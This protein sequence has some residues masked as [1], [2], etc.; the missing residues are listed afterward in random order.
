MTEALYE[1]GFRRF[2]CGGAVGFDT[3]AASCVL[4]LRESRPDARLIL[5]LPCEDQ[6]FHWTPG[7]RSLYRDIREKADRAIVLSDHYYNG[8][9]MVRNRF[10]AYH[11]SFCVAYWLGTA[12]GGTA[13]TVRLA[14][15]KGM[16]VL[17]IAIPEEVRVFLRDT[18]ERIP[19]PF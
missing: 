15:R 1:R 12:S 2:L 19:L 7:E 17:N 14:L 10:M 8:C 16:P 4:E 3:V 13:S 5:A 6:A 9:M 11:A 18:R